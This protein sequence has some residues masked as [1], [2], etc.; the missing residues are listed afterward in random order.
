MHTTTL[1][2][3]RS[4]TQY[5]L[6][7]WQLDG[8]TSYTVTRISEVPVDGYDGFICH[9]PIVS[10]EYPHVGVP[11]RYRTR[12]GGVVSTTVVDIRQDFDTVVLD[13][14]DVTEEVPQ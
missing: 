9:E 12:H 1:V 6:I 2:S 13:N 4:G 5:R 14:L 11:W 7:G 8:E 10:M 3:T